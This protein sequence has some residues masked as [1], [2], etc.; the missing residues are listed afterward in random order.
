MKQSQ[1]VLTQV[2]VSTSYFKL[3]RHRCSSGV[4]IGKG[5]LVH[6]MCASGVELTSRDLT[7]KAQLFTVDGYGRSLRSLYL[8]SGLLT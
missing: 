2:L 6:Y 3:T 7:K 8:L 4:G 5:S 1:A